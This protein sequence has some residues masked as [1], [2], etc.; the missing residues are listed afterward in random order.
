MKKIFYSLFLLLFYSLGYSQNNYS[1]EEIFERA[2]DYSR[3]FLCNNRHE[4]PTA[5]ERRLMNNKD[6]NIE[7]YASKKALE[8]FE[9]LIENFPSSKNISDYYFKLG[10][11]EYNLKSY[12]KSREKL[13]KSIETN[14]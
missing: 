6:Q 3:A 7:D 4:L 8:C 11:L 14:T 13:I 2:N 10:N 5:K 1:E 9:Y 12:E